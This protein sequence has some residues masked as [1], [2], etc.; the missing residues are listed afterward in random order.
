MEN[1]LNKT[2]VEIPIEQLVK[3]WKAGMSTRA[4]AKTYNTSKSAITRRLQKYQQS[5][6]QKLERDIKFL[7]PMEEVIKYLKQGLYYREIAKK[8][9]VSEDFLYN[10]RKEYEKK[11]GKT[12][13]EILSEE[14]NFEINKKRV[15]VPV[16]EV[17]QEWKNGM[18]L[19][20]IAEKHNVSRETI[21]SRLKEYQLKTGEQVIQNKRKKEI[22][23]DE[24]IKEWKKGMTLEKLGQKYGVTRETISKR[25]K[26]FEYKTGQK[27]VRDYIERVPKIDLPIEE[28]IEEWKNGTVLEEIAQKY[29][30][31]RNTIQ[32]R[33]EEYEE[34][35]GEKLVRTHS[36]DKRRIKKELPIEAV[37]EDWKNG[38]TYG[39]LMKKYNASKGT[40]Y[41]RIKEYR[42]QKGDD[43]IRKIIPNVVKE[44]YNNN[45]IKVKKNNKS[46]NPNKPPVKVRMGVIWREYTEGLSV[47]GLALK[48]KTTESDMKKRL[49]QYQALLLTKAYVDLNKSI[50]ELARETK[51]P[52]LE[53]KDKIKMVLR[54]EVKT[55]PIVW[56]LK[57]RTSGWTEEKILKEYILMKRKEEKSKEKMQIELED[58]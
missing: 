43:D 19:E 33:L 52:M 54:K 15:Y 58:K 36:K 17:V 3:E 53:V 38:K 8:Y 13:E 26:E 24:I 16:L 23:L 44:G 31:T 7:I 29:G 49:E 1:E 57:Q 32:R 9:G 11:V 51:L 25:I 28:I 20:D 4:L 10:R 27:L 47:S 21:I 37:Y 6:G 41:K 2:K 50:A 5:T 35:T 55:V 12:V 22:P 39:E 30:V 14:G 46:N 40:I 45:E 48:Y 18:K 56:Y 34:K 42:E